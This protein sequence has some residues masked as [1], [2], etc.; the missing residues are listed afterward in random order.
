[1]RSA[2][3]PGADHT[4]TLRHCQQVGVTVLLPRCTCRRR[5]PERWFLPGDWGPT[6]WDLRTR[7][8]ENHRQTSE[9]ICSTGFPL[10]LRCDSCL[11][12]RKIL[13]FIPESFSVVLN[14]RNYWNLEP[15][16]RSTSLTFY[17]LTG[18]Q[19]SPHLPRF[20]SER[21]WSLP[22]AAPSPTPSCS[23]RSL[24]IMFVSFPN[25]TKA[26]FIFHLWYWSKQSV[27]W[28]NVL[29]DF[30]SNP[31]VWMCWSKTQPNLFVSV[32]LWTKQD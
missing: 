31:D 26:Q 29:F 12:W 17:P 21:P 20:E 10:R 6:H 11:C 30:I 18:G 4:I 19:T 14:L 3:S 2:V 8:K 32:N 24:F 15:L 7:N 13:L 28:S 27:F 23:S 9:W 1:M 16:K 5:L 25:L 22:P